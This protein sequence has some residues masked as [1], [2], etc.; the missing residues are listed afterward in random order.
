MKT[1]PMESIWNILHAMLHCHYKAWQLAESEQV[2]DH[3]SLLISRETLVKIPVSSF[4]PADKLI[5]AA[6]CQS[7]SQVKQQSQKDILV[8]YNNQQTAIVKIRLDNKKAQKLFTE[9]RNVI[10]I[11]IPPAF[12]RNA[13][14][15]ECQFQEDCFKKLKERDCISLLSGISPKVILRFQKKGIYSI[16][17]LSHLFRPR[18]RRRHPQAPTN[19][20]WELKALAIKEHKS[21]KPTG[22]L[23]MGTFSEQGLKSV[24]E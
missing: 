4:T 2:K 15:P 7:Q 23:V 18:R 6:L 22:G 11:D 3:P 9:A 19:Y 10:N 20:L 16:A 5:L 24:A 1:F 21:I 8:E 14:C 17:Q 12:Y 13:H